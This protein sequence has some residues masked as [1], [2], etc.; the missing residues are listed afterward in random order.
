MAGRPVF[1]GAV[2]LTDR[3]VV[4]FATEDTEG[5]AGRA[6]GSLTSVT[7]MVTAIVSVPLLPSSALTVTE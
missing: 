1:D 7:V 3:L 5:A 6:G 2:Q 4:L